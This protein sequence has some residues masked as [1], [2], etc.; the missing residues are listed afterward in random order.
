[1]F[2][3]IALI[4]ATVLALLITVSVA[5]T[6][7]HA[8]ETDWFDTCNT[9]AICFYQQIV[10]GE[11]MWSVSVGEPEEW[12]EWTWQCVNF[13][14]AEPEYN[15][16]DTI[17]AWS[18]K[19]QTSPRVDVRFHIDRNCEGVYS[20]W[21]NDEWVIHYG[22]FPYYGVSSAMIQVHQS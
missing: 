17:V 2:K 14:D 16:E 5:A 11:E 22:Y 15:F 3:R 1:M 6:P 9:G 10:T 7:A 19:W 12:E 21:S 13:Y 4:L 20:S 18:N 8:D